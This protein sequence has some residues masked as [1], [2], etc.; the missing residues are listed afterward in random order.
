MTIVCGSSAPEPHR[1]SD[2][3]SPKS[4]DTSAP[5]ITLMR[6]GSLGFQGEPLAI[7]V[8]PASSDHR[9]SRSPRVE[10]STCVSRGSPRTAPE[11]THLDPCDRATSERNAGVAEDTTSLHL[12]VACV[13]FRFGS[14]CGP[15]RNRHDQKNGN[16]D[17]ARH[18]WNDFSVMR[19]STK[20]MAIGRPATAPAIPSEK[21]RGVQRAKAAFTASR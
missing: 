5:T 15:N 10:S 2:C 12:K 9:E 14:A 11:N 18:H 13:N 1:P 3:V 6:S 16:A 4:M 7:T 20:R 19:S 21:C 8:A 17:E